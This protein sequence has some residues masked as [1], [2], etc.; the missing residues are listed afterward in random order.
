MAEVNSGPLSSRSRKPITTIFSATFKTALMKKDRYPDAMDKVETCVIRILRENGIGAAGI[1]S[2]GLWKSRIFSVCFSSDSDDYALIHSILERGCGKEGL[3]LITLLRCNLGELGFHFPTNRGSF[4]QGGQKMIGHVADPTINVQSVE[5]IDRT[6]EMRK[7]LNAVIFK[8]FMDKGVVRPRPIPSIVFSEGDSFEELGMYHSDS[9]TIRLSP[10]LLPNTDDLRNVLL[11]EAAH[12]IQHSMTGRTA[13]DAAFRDICRELGIKEGFEKAKVH[14]GIEKREKIRDKIEKLLALGS[15]SF[16]AEGES[17]VAK[18]QELMAEY[19]IRQAQCAQ[20]SIYSFTATEAKTRYMEY[21]KEF[22]RL[23]SELSGCT[24]IY[25]ARET[26]GR[27]MRFFGTIDQTEAAIYLYN[28]IADMT[29]EAYRKSL[30][31]SVRR[32]ASGSPFS[33][34]GKYSDFT[35]GF[36]RALRGKL[37]ENAEASNALVL[38]SEKNLEVYRRILSRSSSGSY[39]RTRKSSSRQSFGSGESEGY[40]AGSRAEIPVFSKKS[41]S[42]SAVRKAL[43]S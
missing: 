21:E 20:E 31:D 11:H 28:E 30:C 16:K 40:K 18:A 41:G 2:D 24:L 17:A 1:T 27:S 23:I 19:S 25:M 12:Y 10:S 34:P 36:C 8:W 35:Y 4:F 7:I 29:K 5:I 3:K 33:D 43:C 9:N 38:S 13:H 42:D 26:G 32:F 15:S 14:I 6:N 37:K 22:G 39:V